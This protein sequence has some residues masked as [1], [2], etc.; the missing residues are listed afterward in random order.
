MVCSVLYLCLLKRLLRDCRSASQ[1][2]WRRQLI[3]WPVSWP[4]PAIL[5]AYQHVPLHHLSRDADA[6]AEGKARSCQRS[7]ATHD[8]H[9]LWSNGW[10]TISWHEQQL[11]RLTTH[12]NVV[13]VG[14]NNLFFTFSPVARFQYTPY[15]DFFIFICERRLPFIYERGISSANFI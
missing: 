13:C 9:S 11:P 12:Q 4:P 3:L 1:K 15:L 8:H 14:M 6:Q 5:Q 10:C 7:E 2:R